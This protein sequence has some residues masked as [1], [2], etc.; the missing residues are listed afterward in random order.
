M[1]VNDENSEVLYEVDEKGNRVIVR[2]I[3]SDHCVYIRFINGLI[4]RPV[5]VWWRDFQGKK[6]F[7][8]RMQPRTYFDVDTFVTHPWEFTDAATKE[9]YVIHNKK[10]FR[11][12]P[13]LANMKHRTKWIITVGMRT[14]RNTALLVLAER[15]DVTK[16]PELGL[17]LE[18]SNDLTS[19][20]DSIENM[21]DPPSRT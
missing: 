9:N 17:P 12:P 13:S 10:I 5:D 21:Q 19:L 3:N 11:A 20:I 6:R 16:V 15:L 4:S 1:A 7:Y 8:V 18:L 14:L 2:S